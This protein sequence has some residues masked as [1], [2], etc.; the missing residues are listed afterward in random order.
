MKGK[1]WVVSP[2]SL[3]PHPSEAVGALEE[4]PSRLFSMCLQVPKRKYIELFVYISPFFRNYL[5]HIL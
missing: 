4:H 2:G 5:K 3:C 1:P